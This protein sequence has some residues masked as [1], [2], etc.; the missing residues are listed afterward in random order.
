MLALVLFISKGTISKGQGPKAQLLFRIAFLLTLQSQVGL[1][2]FFFFQL[3]TEAIEKSM[4]ASSYHRYSLLLIK[5]LSYCG[6]FVFYS[7]VEIR[8][9][10]QGEE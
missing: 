10:T 2:V 6:L 9:F 1:V 4:F 3:L 8:F 7:Q 5:L